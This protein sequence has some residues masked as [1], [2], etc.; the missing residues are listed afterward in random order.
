M[1]RFSWTTT[2]SES[3]D[4]LGGSFLAYHLIL[5]YRMFSVW[6]AP[7]ADIMVIDFDWTHP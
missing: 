3:F 4:Y 6:S 2:P 1:D 5:L 7:D